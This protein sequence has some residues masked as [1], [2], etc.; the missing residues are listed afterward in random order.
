MP[1]PVSLTVRRTKL[2]GR[3][4]GLE[5]VLEAVSSTASTAIFNWP[6]SG[7]ASRALNARF[8]INASSIAESAF[9]SGRPGGA[10]RVTLTLSVRMRG[11]ISETVASV[12]RRLT[13]RNSSGCWRLKASN[14]RTRRLARS[15]AVQMLCSNLA[16]TPSGSRMVNS[17]L[18]FPC[19]TVR[20]LLK[21]CATPAAN[22]PTASIFRAC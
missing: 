11:R 20:M 13:G 15:A 1:V 2:P 7:M 21:S 5:P 9:T 17:R 4:S 8:M 10:C 16:S 14:W 19:T 6:P 3:A 18:A 22:W 12:S